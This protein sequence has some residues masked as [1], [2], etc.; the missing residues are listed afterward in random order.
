MQ[1]TQDEKAAAADRR[2]W[3]KVDALDLQL[4]EMRAAIATN[5]QEQRQARSGLEGAIA[6]QKFECEAVR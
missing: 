4:D 3:T 5:L 6:D 2:R 1:E